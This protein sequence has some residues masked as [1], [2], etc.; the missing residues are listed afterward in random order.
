MVRVVSTVSRFFLSPRFK[1]LRLVPFNNQQS[2]SL[3]FWI[4][5]VAFVG[6]VSF[7][8]SDVFR[9]IASMSS[10]NVPAATELAVDTFA[11]LLWLLTLL[12]TINTVR[13]LFSH[14]ETNNRRKFAS[15]WP[16]YLCLLSVIVF[17]LWLLD[18]P[19]LMW[20]AIIF[21]SLFPLT[22]LFRNWVDN[23]FDQAEKIDALHGEFEASTV[24]PLTVTTEAELAGSPETGVVDEGSIET[25]IEEGYTDVHAVSYTH[26]RAHETDS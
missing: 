16:V 18:I 2:R 26:L 20:S 8:I 13:K 5:V 10:S 4:T 3:Q 1:D 7:T 12:L 22:Q 14:G 25:Q 9:Q 17:A 24:Q 11:S 23:L 6:T 15:V 21:G 19:N